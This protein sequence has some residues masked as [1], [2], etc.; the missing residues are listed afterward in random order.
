[1]RTQLLS[2]AD[3]M[4]MGLAVWLCTL[5]IAFAIASFFGLLTGF[6]VALGLLVGITVLCWIL[7]GSQIMGRHLRRQ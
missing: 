2:R 4:V 6:A 7:C 1:M 3:K 5:P